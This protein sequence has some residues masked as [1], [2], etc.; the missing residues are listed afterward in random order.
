ML[1]IHFWDVEAF[2]VDVI[3][4]EVSTTISIYE[5]AEEFLNVGLWFDDSAPKKELA[6]SLGA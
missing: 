5:F 3:S 6:L 2:M 1:L 4:S